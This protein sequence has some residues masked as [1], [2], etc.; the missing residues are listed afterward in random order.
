MKRTFLLLPLLLLL[1]NAC[2]D[3]LSPSTNEGRRAVSATKSVAEDIVTVQIDAPVVFLTEDTFDEWTSIASLEDR[4]K[5]CNVPESAARMLTTEALVKS[6]LNYPLNYLVF[7]YND[8]QMAVDMICERSNLHKELLS[9]PD[10][11]EKL[12]DRFVLTKIDMSVE[13]SSFDQDYE[14]L[15][16]SNEMFLEHFLASGRF[17]GSLDSR[18]KERLRTAV[19]DKLEE[20]VADTAYSAFSS[21]PLMEIGRAKGLGSGVSP[22]SGGDI[23]GQTTVKT[24]FGASLI[25]WKRED[26]SETEIVNMNNAALAQYP[27]AL[28]RYSATAKYNCHSFAW[29][30]H[31]P[32][33]N[34]VWINS[35]ESGI[36][37]LSKYWTDDLYVQT[38][39]SDG[40]RAYYPNGDHSAIVL[41]NGK[42]LSKWGMWPVMEHDWNYGPYITTGMR[43]FNYRNDPLY[44]LT[45]T[46]PTYT[47]LGDTASFS[48]SSNYPDMTYSWTVAYMDS[49]DTSA[50]TYEVVAPGGASCQLKFNQYGLYKITFY[51]YYNGAKVAY[52]YLNAISVGN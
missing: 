40:I 7:A 15:S 17:S 50:G 21:G 3:D 5:A 44:K 10:A 34:D 36:L 28:L 33:T 29:H 49:L 9:R 13:K 48:V 39:A 11:Y 4:F 6:A 46:G 23:I 27:N 8:P 35:E 47:M 2:Q 14:E 42:F 32:N 26:V 30:S 16:Y 12:V 38:S 43:Y 52:G 41:P 24:Y 45:V 31:N 20:R 25:G 19:C 1:S 37:Q 51:G 22:Y 18:T